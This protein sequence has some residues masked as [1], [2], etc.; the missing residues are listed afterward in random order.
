MG[1]FGDVLTFLFIFF[2][3]GTVPGPGFRSEVS[4]VGVMGRFEN[5]LT[6]RFVFLG[7]CLLNFKYLWNGYWT[8]E[9]NVMIAQIAK[10]MQK[11]KMLLLYVNDTRKIMLKVLIKLA[12]KIFAFFFIK[13]TYSCPIFSLTSFLYN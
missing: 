13:D 4:W 7:F 1:R 11:V 6:F 8:M 2:S 5:V 3:L 10:L 9:F 12:T